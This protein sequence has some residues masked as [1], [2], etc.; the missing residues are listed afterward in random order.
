[1]KS[2]VRV[3]CICVLTMVVTP[4]VVPQGETAVP[5]LLITSSPEG[6]GMGGISA[7]LITDNAMAANSNP[8]QVGLFGL[9]GHLN[10][11]FYTRKT[12]WLPMFQQSDATYNTGAVSA[13]FDLGDVLSLPFPVGIGAGYSKIVLNLGRFVV[14][15]PSGPPP[16]ANLYPKEEAEAYTV[17]V[18]IDYY[19]RIGFG[20][21]FKRI[22]SSPGVI[23]DSRPSWQPTL[24][25]ARV[26]ATDF[27]LLIQVPLSEIVFGSHEQPLGF[28]P[29]I[30][31]F[32]NLSVGYVHSNHGKEVVYIDSLGGDP[33]PR[34]AVI[35]LGVEMGLISKAISR[36]WRVVSVT[37]ARQAED[38]LVRRFSDGSF[39]YQ[40]GLGDIGFFNSIFL[41][42]RNDRAS[43]RKGWEF[44][45]AELL[46]VRGGSYAGPG[47]LV[48]STSGF[49]VRSRGIFRL[50]EAFTGSELKGWL[51]SLLANHVD[52][53][54]HQSSYRSEDSPVDGTTFRG[55]NLTLDVL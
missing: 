39:S 21:S 40:S 35:G 7:S 25:E 1:M 45:I 10:A 51:V 12:Q 33:L 37:W 17:G 22:V 16:I 47:Y 11:G 48:Y 14:T 49:S 44:S 28:L 13:G 41:G 42:E 31:P 53:Q 2:T 24:M 34:E 30:D 26:S 23:I 38:L 43:L 50:V 52:V 3:V 27:G 4:E 15:G 18:G 54:F 36:D 5:F 19:V 46:Y 20:L 6:N 55:L 9:R 8:A 29:D 32:V